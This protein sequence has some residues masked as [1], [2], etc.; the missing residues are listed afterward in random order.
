M[1]IF[2][3]NN[4]VIISLKDSY[5]RSAKQTRTQRQK[6]QKNTQNYKLSI[7]SE[8]NVVVHWWFWC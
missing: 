1:I 5:Q 8:L 4:N 7:I 3:H 2:N 6:E